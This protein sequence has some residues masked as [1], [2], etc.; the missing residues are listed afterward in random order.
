MNEA[1]QD[2][3]SD[4]GVGNTLMPV[5]DGELCHH[6][7][8]AA[9]VAIVHDLEQIARLHRSEWIAEPVVEDEQTDLGERIE[10]SWVRAVGMG[11]RQRIEQS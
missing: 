4:R 9:A 10:Q 3:I 2:G 5:C 8:G 7:G 6:H 11:M 1:I